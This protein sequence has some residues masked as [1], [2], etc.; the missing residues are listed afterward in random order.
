MSQFSFFPPNSSKVLAYPPPGDGGVNSEKYTPL[1]QNALD[2]IFARE[3]SK[4]SNSKM[5]LVSISS[6]KDN[7]MN[8]VHPEPSDIQH[9]FKF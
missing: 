5:L 1:S 8:F 9:Y 7:T 6:L 3:F 4:S 2:A